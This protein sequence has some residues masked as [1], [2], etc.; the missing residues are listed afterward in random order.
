MWVYLPTENYT[1]IRVLGKLF[2]ILK[3]ASLLEK[4]LCLS[5]SK[6]IKR[7][8]LGVDLKKTL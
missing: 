8:T 6:S 1:L 3:L 2:A 5:T 4:G 7:L